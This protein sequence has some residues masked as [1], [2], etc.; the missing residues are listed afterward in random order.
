MNSELTFAALFGV[1]GSRLFLLVTEF[2]K[3]YKIEEYHDK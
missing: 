1:F 3:V 2:H